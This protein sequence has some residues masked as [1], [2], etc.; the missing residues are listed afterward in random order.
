MANKSYLEKLKDIQDEVDNMDSRVY[1]LEN[2]NVL[3]VE[4]VD[5]FVKTNQT[6]L[7]SLV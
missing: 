2:E 3:D 1:A 5:S 7:I 4:Q 6:I